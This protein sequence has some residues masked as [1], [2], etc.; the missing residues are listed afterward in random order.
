MQALVTKTRDSTASQLR[1]AKSAIMDFSLDKM[2]SRTRE[3]ARKHP[4]RFGSYGTFCTLALYWLSRRK[5]REIVIRALRSTL[6][7][8]KSRTIRNMIVAAST[9]SAGF[10]FVGAPINRPFTIAMGLVWVMYYYFRVIEH[11][12]AKYKHTFWNVHIVQKARLT[13]TKFY[14]VIWGFNRHSQTVVCFLLAHFEWLWSSKIK[15]HRETVIGND[16][17]P[18]FID[19]LHLGSK[20]KH[21]REE[22]TQFGP[23]SPICLL[24]HGLGD[25]ND[26]PYMKRFARMCRRHGWRCVAFS[27]WRF[28]FGEI[29]DLDLVI[30]HIHKQF[31]SAPMIAIA[32]SA[33][34]HYLLKY[35]GV[36][37]KDTPLVA[38]ISVSGCFDFMQAVDDI[39]R[40][41]NGSYLKF[42]S[43]QVRRCAKRHLETDNHLID[44][45]SF[46]NLRG[47]SL[48]DPLRYYDKFI[49]NIRHWSSMEE[50][51]DKRPYRLMDNTKTHYEDNAFSRVSGVQVSTL[52]LHAVDDPVVSYKHIDWDEVT[53]NKHVIVL[54]TRRGGHVAWYE[55]FFPFGATWSEKVSCNFISAVLETQAHTS[56]LLDVFRRATKPDSGPKKKIGG[57]VKRRI[58]EPTL[59]APDRIAR[60]CSASDLTAEWVTN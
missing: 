19:W 49:F 58:K 35:L 31:P 54:T 37:G 9:L 57:G 47:I 27:Y 13:R 38:A 20:K 45:S 42:L 26:H 29:G 22:E 60:I 12:V 4:Y 48:N 28:D 43:L 39:K 5:Q 52:I 24:I 55:G 10:R 1:N 21:K 11:G 41:E 14:P 6:L 17:N 40:A 32:W 18:Q 16:G 15:V 51:A 50:G 23:E 2:I 25:D 34:G 36:K 46:V 7:A 56:F 3:Y 33:G 53:N 30:E 44:E 8:L 59:L